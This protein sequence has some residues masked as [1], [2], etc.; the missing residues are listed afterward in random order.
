MAA[1]YTRTPTGTLPAIGDPDLTGSCY[2]DLD[3][4]GANDPPPATYVIIPYPAT[5]AAIL[6][7][8]H[9][10]APRAP[11]NLILDLLSI[12]IRVIEK[13]QDLYGYPLP[14]Y[15]RAGVPLI[16]RPAESI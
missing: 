10:P 3:K 5:T 16:H 4:G 8:M 14:N 13:T 2:L 7:W 11:I 12:N 6:I 9:V 1:T 15:E